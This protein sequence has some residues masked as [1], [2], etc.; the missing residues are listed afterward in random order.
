[1]L[2]TWA[3]DVPRLAVALRDRTGRCGILEYRTDRQLTVVQVSPYANRIIYSVRLHRTLKLP[4]TYKMVAVRALLQRTLCCLPTAS[5]ESEGGELMIPKR[6]I[7][8]LREPG[9]HILIVTTATLPW[10]T[11]TAVN[12]LLRAAYVAHLLTDSK[13]ASLSI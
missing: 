11:G 2:T 8:S 1:M 12:P 13:V 4:R 3:F 7:S 6:G 9:R 5:P 10:R